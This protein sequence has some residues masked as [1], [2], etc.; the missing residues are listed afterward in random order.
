MS[1][2]RERLA[3]H[4]TSFRLNQTPK[5]L[6]VMEYLQLTNTRRMKAQALASLEEIPRILKAKITYRV[7]DT[8]IV[9]RSKAC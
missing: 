9:K 1:Q 7:T 5:V 6:K 4:R 2:V 8:L 3:G